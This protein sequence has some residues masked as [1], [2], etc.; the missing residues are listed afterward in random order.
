MY[1]IVFPKNNENEFIK[2]AKELGYTNLCFVYNL[3]EFKKATDGNFAG[4]ITDE[5]NLNK[6][7][8]LADFVILQSS[9]KD[10]H[11]IESGKAEIIFNLETTSRKDFIHH[12]ASGLN[13]VLCTL[14]NKKE[15][16]IAFS[17]NTILKSEGMLRSQI[18]GRMMQNIR[19][20]RKYKFNLLFASFAQSPFEMRAPHDLIAFAE[21]LDMHPSEAKAAIKNTKTTIQQ[22]TKKKSSNYLCDGIEL[23]D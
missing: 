15:V 21:T 14:L 13:Q 19:F 7:K 18:M 11:L 1:D 5:K 3:N 16:A 23:V 10:R 9:D 2:I 8:K 17:F 12:R 6:A 4:I 20:A 22:I